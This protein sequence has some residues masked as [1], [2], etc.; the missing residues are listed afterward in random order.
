MKLNLH[1]NVLLAA[2]VIVLAVLCFM[3]VDRPLSFSNEQK[4]RE[5]VVERQMDKIVRAEQQYRRRKGVYTR[6]F[7]V[8]TAEGLLNK[9]DR[10]V[11]FSKKQCFELDATTE[12]GKSGK[13]IPQLTCGTR[14]TVYLQGLDE[15]KINELSNL[16]V[17]MGNYPGI[18]LTAGR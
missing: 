11:P 5:K 6:S 3:S 15:D 10:Y 13:I 1:N 14:Y 12:V 16:A 7:D 8:L 2:C 18:Q 17:A 4:Q 9:D